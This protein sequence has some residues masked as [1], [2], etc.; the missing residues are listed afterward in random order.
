QPA[1]PDLKDV[2]PERHQMS[3]AVAGVG[4]GRAFFNEAFRDFSQKTQRTAFAAAIAR[5]TVPKVANDRTPDHAREMIGKALAAFP[6]WRDT[7]HIARATCL[8][9]AAAAMRAQRDALSGVMIKESGKTWREADADVCE[10]IDFCEY[11]AR[12]AVGLFERKRV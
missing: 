12:M 7:D 5:A 10:A 4:D 8:T 11:Y 3:P 2:G 1:K 9:K 6:A